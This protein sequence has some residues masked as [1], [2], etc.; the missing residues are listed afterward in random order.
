MNP[1]PAFDPHTPANKGGSSA[2]VHPARTRSL[3]AWPAWLRML[4][5]APMLALLWL[6]VLWALVDTAP[7]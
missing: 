4:V 1:V 5:V 2:S 7:R 3:L 6:A